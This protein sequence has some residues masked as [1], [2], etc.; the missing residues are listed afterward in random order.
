M[1]GTVSAL[2]GD[3][4]KGE[5]MT[6]APSKQQGNV[7]LIETIDHAEQA[8]LEAVRKFLDTVD[9]A[10]PHLGED[11]PRRTAIDST[12]KMIEQL[13]TA[14][15]GLAKNVVVI[16]QTEPEA[17]TKEAVAPAKPV[18]ATKS[19]KSAKKTTTRKAATAKRRPSTG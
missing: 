2:G 18:K 4:E 9:D 19:A 1:G 13:V 6:A 15:T 17:T 5:D 7:R 12:F 8:A 11:K 14:A 16:T 10:F 3:Q